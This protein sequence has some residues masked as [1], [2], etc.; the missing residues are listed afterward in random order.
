MSNQEIKKINCGNCLFA[1]ICH[2]VSEEEK[3]CAMFAQNP[4]QEIIE[5][6]DGQPTEAQEWEPIEG[7][8]FE[9]MYGEE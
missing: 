5:D 2:Q 6:S 7:E 4:D 8:P 1:E 9:S 3:Y